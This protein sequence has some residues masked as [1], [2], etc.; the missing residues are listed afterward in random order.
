MVNSPLEQ[1][2]KCHDR[3]NMICF[4]DI[5]SSLK[6]EVRVGSGEVS[7]TTDSSN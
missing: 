2:D 6:I 5:S 3:L 1:G 4:S 7:E